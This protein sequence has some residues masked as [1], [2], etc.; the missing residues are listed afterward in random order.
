VVGVWEVLAEDDDAGCVVLLP[1]AL[2]R[3]LVVLVL[4]E[5]EELKEVEE[6]E[7][8]EEAID[9]V[10]VAAS[11]PTAV[12]VEM[13]PS[14]AKTTAL[15]LVQHSPGLARSVGQHTSVALFSKRH[16]TIQLPPLP[17]PAF[18]QNLGQAGEVQD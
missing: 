7:E 2:D 13:L 15:G 5:D 16:C 11:E 4:E 8:V 12:M 18:S 14:R 9:L 17:P 3:V 6:V 10:R 1:A